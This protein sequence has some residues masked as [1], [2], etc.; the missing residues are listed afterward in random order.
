MARVNFV[1]AY[2][3]SKRTYP[4][5]HPALFYPAP[6]LL[7]AKFSSPSH[8]TNN[9]FIPRLFISGM[10]LPLLSTAEY[11]LL[12][13]PRY[14]YLLHYHVAYAMMWVRIGCGIIFLCIRVSSSYSSRSPLLEYM[15][16][17]SG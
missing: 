3:Q 8:F 14:N 17:H 2:R 5:L 9:L 1:T 10:T 11:S 16:Y 4:H 13:S 6:R 15:F 12:A 7:Y